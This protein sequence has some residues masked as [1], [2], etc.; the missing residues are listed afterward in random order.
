MR[1]SVAHYPRDEI[2]KSDCRHGYENEIERF[3]KS[4][5]FLDAEHDGSD[6]DVHDQH[7]ERHRNGQVELVVDRVH[8]KG[9]GAR[10]S[11]RKSGLTV[12]HATEHV[13]WSP[14]LRNV[15]HHLYAFHDFLEETTSF[16]F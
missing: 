8:A 13:A 10:R 11:R 3:E 16:E 2:S 14:E 1:V 15:V 9:R 5:S 12:W 7:D 6:Y 4:P